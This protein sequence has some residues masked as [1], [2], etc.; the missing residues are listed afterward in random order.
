[1]AGAAKAIR[2]NEATNARP[3][4][5][6]EDALFE[7][8]RFEH[9]VTGLGR[10]DKRQPQRH[11]VIEHR[12]IAAQPAALQ[13]VA[14]QFLIRLEQG[15]KLRVEQSPLLL[16]A[17]LF[18][19]VAAHLL[20]EVAAAVVIEEDAHPCR[21]DV[22][23]QFKLQPPVID[24]GRKQMPLHLP[25]DTFEPQAVAGARGVARREDQIVAGRGICKRG[26][27]SGKQE[28]EGGGAELHDKLENP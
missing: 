26:N 24:I 14:L 25:G 22:V 10:V 20:G 8:Q 21:I 27:E 5:V 2:F 6:C 16:L 18:Q 23:L 15:G 7:N 3:H 12:R 11:G 19:P 28:Q 13:G 4:I 9:R 17:K 1:M